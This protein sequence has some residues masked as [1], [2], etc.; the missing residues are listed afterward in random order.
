MWKCTIVVPI[1]KATTDQYH[2]LSKVYWKLTWL[3]KGHLYLLQTT[4]LL[5]NGAFRKGD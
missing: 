3:N 1:P 4:L 5:T 2:I